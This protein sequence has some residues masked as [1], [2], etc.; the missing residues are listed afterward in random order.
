[1]RMGYGRGFDIGVFGSVFGHNVTQNLPVLGIQSL[2][3]A[4]NFDVGVHAGARP[5]N[6]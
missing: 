2:Q 3:P 1:M 6:A 5:D 4:R